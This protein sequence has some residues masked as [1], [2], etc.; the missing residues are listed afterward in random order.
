MKTA[1]SR[2]H[3][4]HREQAGGRG[5]SLIEYLLIAAVVIVALMAVSGGVGERVQDVASSALGRIP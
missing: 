5:Q 3:T 4:A 1:H 2:Q